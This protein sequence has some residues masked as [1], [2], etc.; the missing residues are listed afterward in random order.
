MVYPPEWFCGDSILTDFPYVFLFFFKK[1][2]SLSNRTDRSENGT[3]KV[4]IK[5]ALGVF[6][7]ISIK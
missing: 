7:F 1:I 3:L 6:Y 4:D 5:S 2:G